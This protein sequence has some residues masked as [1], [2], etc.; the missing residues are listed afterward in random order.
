FFNVEVCSNMESRAREM[1]IFVRGLMQGSPDLSVLT[2]RSIR[3]QFLK[4]VG[5][6]SMEKE[7]KLILKKIV[8][9]ELLKMQVDDPRDGK[10]PILRIVGEKT[11]KR[12]RGSS[13]SSSDDGAKRDSN[14][15]KLVKPVP[16]KKHLDFSADEHSDTENTRTTLKETTVKLPAA[17][18]ADKEISEGLVKSSGSRKEAD[19]PNGTVSQERGAPNIGK[20]KGKVKED[21]KL[22]EIPRKG[23]TLKVRYSESSS[24]SEETEEPRK[25]KKPRKMPLKK[26]LT[27]NSSEK[28]EDEITIADSRTDK[29]SSDTALAER[30]EEE[31][32][33]KKETSQ[34]GKQP[35]ARKA[36]HS[37]DSSEEEGELE[38]R[39]KKG[40]SKEVTKQRNKTYQSGTHSEARKC[41]TE[42]EG[43]EEEVATNNKGM[44]IGRPQQKV[45]SSSCDE[46]EEE[47]KEHSGPRAKAL[48]AKKM[49]DH[50]SREQTVP[51]M[52]S[53]SKGRVSKG[54]E[55]ISGGESSA[56]EKSENNLTPRG[57]LHK[58]RKTQSSNEEDENIDKL[59]MTSKTHSK[60]IARDSSEEMEEEPKAKKVRKAS[61]GEAMPTV[62]QNILENNM[63]TKSRVSDS[64]ED[65]HK[66]ST[67]ES[68]SS[69]SADEEDLTS[70]KMKGE[71]PSK[72]DTKSRMDNSS[73]EEANGQEAPVPSKGKSGAVQTTKGTSKVP[74]EVGKV[75]GPNSSNDSDSSN[76]NSIAKDSSQPKK[77]H[78]DGGSA[79]SSSSDDDQVDVRKMQVA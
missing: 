25:L 6:T 40:S 46:E 55:A 79:T 28:E 21:S 48:K 10:S 65:T 41:T 19:I 42:S 14:S 45:S 54:Q 52:H 34:R 60:S 35:K 50:D 56:E 11:K 75:P 68:A 15:T 7:E 77:D 47:P 3:E 67:E 17:N 1:K 72:T 4:H 64:G 27:E 51:Q 22:K 69:G 20:L 70:R 43:S 76:G 29:R 18:E 49:K 32:E 63:S 36:N 59:E 62:K 73:E 16:K 23:R 12:A 5:C 78:H 66:A 74:A 58:P 33:P 57:I 2:Q 31:Q 9:K 53:N 37:N 8:E 71:A 44:W 61:S 38:G 13:C 26:R 24:E 39:K 30:S